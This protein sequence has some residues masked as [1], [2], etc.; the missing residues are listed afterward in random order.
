MT[1]SLAARTRQPVDHADR[2]LQGTNL[3]YH[4]E[5]RD[6]VSRVMS[7]VPD[8]H[9]ALLGSISVR[10]DKDEGVRGEYHRRKYVARTKKWTPAHITVTPQVMNTPEYNKETKLLEEKGIL[11]KSGLPGA[12]VALHHE[13]GHHL[14]EQMNNEKRDNMWNAIGDLPEFKKANPGSSQPVSPRFAASNKSTLTK[15]VSAYAGLN[16]YEAAA[17]LYAQHHGKYPTQASHVAYQHM[18]GGAH[19]DQSSDEG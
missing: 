11:R 14:Y 18:T 8:E 1:A 7:H 13:V 4:N 12:E 5:M 15:H 3:Q 16:H 17:E 9:A 10:P 19:D 6:T 2:V